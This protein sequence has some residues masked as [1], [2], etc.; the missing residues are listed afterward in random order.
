M[1]PDNIYADII[2]R[3]QAEK[4]K[5]RHDTYLFYLKMCRLKS[6]LE[7]FIADMDYEHKNKIGK[8]YYVVDYTEIA[9]YVYPDENIENYLYDI[10]VMDD[11]KRKQKIVKRWYRLRDLFFNNDKLTFILPPHKEEIERDLRYLSQTIVDKQHELLDIL[12]EYQQKYLSH[13]EYENIKKIIENIAVGDIDI[14]KTDKDLNVFFG[15]YSLKIAS[16]TCDIKY[17]I[18]EDLD[19]L[20]RLTSLLTM[21]NIFDVYK[22]EWVQK[23]SISDRVLEKIQKTKIIDDYVLVE[24]VERVLEFMRG[25][26]KKMVSNLID[27]H[28]LVYMHKINKILKEEGLKHI[29]IHFVTSALSIYRLNKIIPKEYLDVNIRHPKFLPGLMGQKSQIWKGLMDYELFYISKA[30]EE[31]LKNY[32][33]TK[34]K[35]KK[36]LKFILMSEV[37]S[38]WQEIESKI[39]MKEVYEKE[40]DCENIAIDKGSNVNGNNDVIEFM[41]YLTENESGFVKYM[42]ESYKN[43]FSDL[44][45]YYL[46]TMINIDKY[47][48][49]YLD[50]NDRA[51][52]M[53]L[54]SDGI[55]SVIEFN[56]ELLI[57]KLL[58]TSGR[59][60]EFGLLVKDIL[61]GEYTLVD[62]YEEIL[63]RSLLLA[64]Q[65]AWPLVAVLCQYAIDYKELG[66]NKRDAYEA[67]YLLS[68]TQRIIA[69]E[70]LMNNKGIAKTYFNYAKKNLNIAIKSKKQLDYRFCLADSAAYLEYMYYP[71]YKKNEDEYDVIVGKINVCRK[72]L[73]DIQNKNKTEYLEYIELRAYQILISYYMMQY[74]GAYS[75]RDV[76]IIKK[77]ELVLWY[78]SLMN[79][80]I[81]KNKYKHWAK[82][83]DVIKYAVPLILSI[84]KFNRVECENY[85]NEIYNACINLKEYGY[86]RRL[87]H[88]LK[89]L[90]LEKIKSKYNITDDYIEKKWEY[91]KKE[92]IDKSKYKKNW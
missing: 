6:D 79:Y 12:D 69:F 21:G 85:F 48:A 86:Y 30:I 23:L 28:A 51:Y 84:D 77:D 33:R 31:Y 46:K 68:I 76:E 7:E 43:V 73:S 13:D 1:V 16:L 19:C 34:G 82:S 15:E 36:D 57:S 88:D 78:D 91:L 17:D 90:L 56:D 70:R 66:N 52:K 18:K 47:K 41:D 27:A 50:D 59:Y 22:S 81:R 14:G 75:F 58:R 8:I 39:F 80:N 92:I 38:V 89:V 83:I 71:E 42:S 74:L 24:Q 65:K 32:K 40:S 5:E 63:I 44:M 37:S 64:T 61:D 87:V 49:V 4:L 35:K 72:V 10:E 45:N 25:S 54:Q 53:F 55:R 3:L 29:E 11:E 9:S 62:K 26:G 20:K 2:K 60:I 67:H